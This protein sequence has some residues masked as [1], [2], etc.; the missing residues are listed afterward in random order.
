MGRRKMSFHADYFIFR[1]FRCRLIWRLCQRLCSGFWLV[2]KHLS[3]FRIF[4][5]I[6]LVPF[7]ATNSSCNWHRRDSA[8]TNSS[9]KNQNTSPRTVNVK[10]PPP[11][12]GLMETACGQRTEKNIFNYCFVFLVDVHRHCCYCRNMR[13][14]APT[15]WALVDFRTFSDKL[16][17][18]TK[19][20]LPT[21]STFLPPLMRNPWNF[22]L[23]FIFTFRLFSLS[24]LCRSS[25]V[26]F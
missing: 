10:T 1:L 13:F 19:P 24:P 25:V 12:R 7:A 14:S 3:T 6:L 4:N 21:R 20:C 16:R 9:E 18:R 5:F 22:I 23:C 11:P 26:S 17:R 2:R 8:G 15:D